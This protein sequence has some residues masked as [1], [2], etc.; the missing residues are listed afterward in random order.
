MGNLGIECSNLCKNKEDE[1]EH[2]NNL[3]PN[4][5]NKT[6]KN[7]KYFSTEKN[8]KKFNEIFQKQ[9][10][11][12]GKEISENEF[13]SN[14]SEEIQT[15]LTNNVYDYTPFLKQ[16]KP[17]YEARPVEFKN[18][19]I[20]YGNWNEDAQMEGYGKL[21]LKK[22]GVFTEGV[23]D[24]GMLKEGRIFLS[25]GDIYEGNIKNST[26]NGKGK[27][28]GKDGTFFEGEYKNGLKNGSGKLIYPDNS[29]YMG[30][31]KDDN[32]D[33]NGEFEWKDGFNYKGYFKNNKLN[34]KGTIINKKTGSNYTG[35]FVNNYFEGKGKFNFK[36]GSI[37][38][39]EFKSNK[40]DGKGTYYNINKNIK[41]EG[42][43]LE[44]KQHGFGKID[45]GNNI[46][47]CTWRNGQT[48]ENPQIEGDENIDKDELNNIIN[49]N[50]EDIDIFPEN[51]PYIAQNNNRFGFFKPEHQISIISETE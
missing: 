33:G 13:N 40:R 5:Q 43:W 12:F 34:G 51:L 10:P 19:N 49:F 21:I 11:N 30:N 39:G 35:N 8:Q 31:F 7:K 27:L 2:F 42:D 1:L 45:D 17:T 44:D 4:I 24:E 16:N 46:I 22:E 25:N 47:K 9:L 50:A 23:W 26:F 48:V 15:Y 6:L 32:L 3:S 36:S 14:I 29:V 20:Y 18:G 41:Y 28:I 37:Y 38:E